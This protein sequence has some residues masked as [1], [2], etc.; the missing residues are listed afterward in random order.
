MDS[1]LQDAKGPERA[2]FNDG[3]CGAKTGT[4]DSLRRAR[5]LQAIQRLFRGVREALTQINAGV[6]RRSDTGVAGELPTIEEL[7]QRIATTGT[8]AA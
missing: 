3:P 1:V 7:R 8:C 4:L 5:A 6:L 2:V